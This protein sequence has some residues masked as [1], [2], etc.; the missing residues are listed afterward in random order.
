MT[1]RILIDLQPCQ[2]ESRLRGLGRYAINMTREIVDLAGPHT[3]HVLLNDRYSEVIPELRRRLKALPDH[4]VH[5]VQMLAQA[6][7]AN[8]ENRWRYNASALLREAY[9]A[10][11]S[12][13]VVF[14]PSFFEGFGDDTALSIGRLASVPTV[15]AIH[16]LIPLAL[17]DR[18]L[19]PSPDY[20]RHYRAKLEEVRRVDG[21]VAISDY[22]LNEFVAR[23]DFPADRIVNAS[24]G[25]ESKFRPLAWSS[26]DKSE[27]RARFG[28][29]KDFIFYTGGADPRK[30]L[31]RLIEAYAQLPEALRKEK[32]LV[33]AGGISASERSHLEKTARHHGLPTDALK[34]LGYVNDEQLIELFNLCDAFVF[35]S[36][37][38]GFGLPCLEAMQ[39]GAP[40]IG[41]NVSS[42]P[43]IIGNADALFDPHSVQAI[44]DRLERVLTDPAFR[45]DLVQ[46]GKVQAAKFSWAKSGEL[47]LAKLRQVAR[48]PNA[49]RTW[50]ETVSGLDAVQAKLVEKISELS[51]T[52]GPPAA[53]DLAELA[54][55]AAGNRTAA[56]NRLRP[57]SLSQD[58]VWRIEGP[59]DSSYSLALVN[60]EL[61]LGLDRLGTKVSLR[62]SDGPGDYPPSS[63]FLKA[64]AE[65]AALSDSDGAAGDAQI[66]SRNMYPPRTAGMNGALNG[67]SCYA[68]E[69]SAFPFAYA[70][71]I[72]E[73]AQFVTATS[74]HVKKV[75]IDAGVSV[76]IGVAG[77][78]VDHWQ[79]VE[80]DESYTVATAGHVFLHV[81]SCFPRK[82]AD[83]LL[84]SYGEAFSK[85]DDVLLIIKTFPNPHNTIERQL[86]EARAANPD[87]PAVAL[88]M[89]DLSDGQLKSLYEQCDT[90][91]APSRAEGFGLPMAEAMLSGLHVITTNWSGHLDF[92]DPENVSLIDFHFEP[93]AT[94][95]EGR[96]ISA[97][98]EPDG[99]H[100]AQLM[101]QTVDRPRSEAAPG[102][103][104]NWS[105]DKVAQ[106]SRRWLESIRVEDLTAEPRL[107]WVT[108]YQKQCGIATYSEHLLDVFGIPT[109]VLADDGDGPRSTDAVNVCRCW[110]E[111][112]PDTLDRL[113]Q[114]IEDHDLDTIVIQ[115]N[116]AFFDFRY[117]SELINALKDESK[118]VVVT[119]HATADPAHDQT[120]KLAQLIDAFS[121]CDRLFVHSIN[122][123][124]QLKRYGLINN[125]ALFPHGLLV[126]PEAE[127]QKRPS[128]GPVRFASYGFFL[129]NKGLIELIEAANLWKQEGFGFHLHLVNS[130]YPA[131]VSQQ[132]IEQAHSLVA[133]YQLKEQVRLTT[134]FL[135]DADSLKMLSEADIIV[136]PYQSTAE[137]ASGA[138]RYG[139]SVGKPVAVTP[140]PIFDDVSSSVFQLPGTSP[141]VLALG[142]KELAE[143]VRHRAPAVEDT[144][145]RASDWRSIH[146]YPVLARRLAGTIRALHRESLRKRRQD[147]SACN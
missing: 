10:M 132:L 81:S 133:R 19:D 31:D 90:L 100:L 111:G 53:S 109:V 18:Y 46:M 124:N 84:R 47:A 33:F 93:A 113:K 54:Q 105:W 32:Q 40:T 118:T 67:L 126:A 12:P 24:E 134:D 101:Q 58:D 55:A 39:C 1:A 92:C 146:A 129:P 60:R 141:A 37:Y 38:E 102:L 78:G 61:A 139:L 23:L 6:D 34:L 65:V 80:A 98:A 59:F 70:E 85:H 142:L 122:D 82:G 69:E 71:G 14:L 114:A 130:A 50:T 42:L 144:L 74:E 106:R 2:N 13:D 76:P 99:A 119:L 96:S 63:A 41:A 91:V 68:W 27:A 44:K 77:N 121:R 83:V 104:D 8:P 7:D 25:A 75:L 143:L 89:D 140:L 20:A 9:I 145:R 16:D 29:R 49:P 108:T 43:E 86:Q 22:S 103:L 94:H 120:K 17:S 57:Y 62:S 116:Y 26:A 21:A 115:F 138:V 127:A 64:N 125:V 66:V 30:N 28:I 35:P 11:I 131:D 135:A 5:V 3:V 15:A 95:Q 73:Y 52:Y 72:N 112:K 97:W 128:R 48:A 88:I 79:N 136:Y 117:L 56:E 36:F 45:D 137:S 87:Y 110:G 123:L 4:N 51:S 147:L 107:G